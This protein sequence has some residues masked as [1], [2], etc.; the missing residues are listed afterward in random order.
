MENQVK[1]FDLLAVVVVIAVIAMGTA[2][3]I[4]VANRVV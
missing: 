1:K 2:L 4:Y 3:G